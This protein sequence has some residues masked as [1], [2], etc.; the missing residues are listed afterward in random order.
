VIGW[1][2]GEFDAA[3]PPIQRALAAASHA[4]NDRLRATIAASWANLVLATEDR[5]EEAIALA[6]VAETWATEPTALVGCRTARAR[7][8]V[9]LGDVQ[10][11]DKLG[12][13][14]VSLAEQTDS[15]DLRANALLHLAEVLRLSG[16]PN[17]AQ[18]FERR[19][20]RLLDRKGASAQAAAVFRNL[21]AEGLLPPSGEDDAPDV[22]PEDEDRP[23]SEIVADPP[24]ATVDELG[25][26]PAAP[27][28]PTPAAAAPPE[29]EPE[30]APDDADD[31]PPPPP[32]AEAFAAS[33]EAEKK[34]RGRFRR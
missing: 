14:A 16:R 13:E 32:I 9:R 18:P 23:A 22:A 28:E 10:R 1:L 2:A 8:L 5:V 31:R 15:T 4:R 33:S 11:A 7:A 12:R 27:T 29:P 30:G 25:W 20:F 26:E 21:S 3:E 6:D 34:K 17:E 24:D 19:A